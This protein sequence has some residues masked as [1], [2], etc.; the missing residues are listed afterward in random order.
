MIAPRPVPLLVTK[1]SSVTHWPAK[2]SFAPPPEVIRQIRPIAAADGQR[3]RE[4]AEQRE[5]VGETSHAY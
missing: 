1:V 3:H 2:L 5:E 4:A